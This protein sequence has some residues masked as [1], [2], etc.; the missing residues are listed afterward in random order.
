[1]ASPLSIGTYTMSTTM[2]SMSY[3]RSDGKVRTY[4]HK[5]LPPK[6]KPL[7]TKEMEESSSILCLSYTLSVRSIFYSGF[8]TIPSKRIQTFSELKWKKSRRRD[9]NLGNFMQQVL[10]WPISLFEMAQSEFPSHVMSSTTKMKS[11]YLQMKAQWTTK[12]NVIY[13]MGFQFQTSLIEINITWMCLKLAS[14]DRNAEYRYLMLQ[15]I[16]Q[17]DLQ[18]Q[19]YTKSHSSAYTVHKLTCRM[20]CS[21][22]FVPAPK[23]GVSLWAQ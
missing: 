17:V 12:F 13:E 6:S 21:T 8:F 20:F 9:W 16:L 3:T 15:S 19:Q 2:A 11:F 1:M 5:G 10:P 7:S 23:N 22:P 14:C 4:L 18:I